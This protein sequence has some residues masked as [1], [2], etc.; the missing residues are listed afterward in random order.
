M[1]VARR[2]AGI[3]RA[4][5]TMAGAGGRKRQEDAMIKSALIVI[6]STALMTGV[7]A[8]RYRKSDV[9]G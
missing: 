5:Q 6:I 3:Q 9:E 8:R 7:E 1:L 4:H 2:A